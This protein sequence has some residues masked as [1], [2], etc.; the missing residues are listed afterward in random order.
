[1]QEPA[2][3]EHTGENRKKRGF[4][5]DVA[6][7]KSQHTCGDS[8]IGHCEG[9]ILMRSEGEL[10]K[11]DDYVRQNEKSIDDGIGLVGIQIFERDEH[12]LVGL[13]RGSR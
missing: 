10:E 3:E 8:G 6:I 4:K 12:E 7:E 5:A 2:V 9:V 13:L 11:K 1:M